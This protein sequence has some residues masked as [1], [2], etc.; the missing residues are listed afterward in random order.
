MLK[1][2]S[3]GELFEIYDFKIFFHNVPHRGA[4]CYISKPILI[5]LDLHSICLFSLNILADVLIETPL[6]FTL[7]ITLCTTSAAIR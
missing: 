7:K 3:I 2:S 6:S 4:H 1:R 5:L